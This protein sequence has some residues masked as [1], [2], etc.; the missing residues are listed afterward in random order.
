[1]EKTL[2]FAL[3]SLLDQVK[4]AHPAGAGEQ[5]Q[6]YSDRVTIADVRYAAEEAKDSLRHRLRS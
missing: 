3:K 6:T 4:S 1:M 5:E 2:S